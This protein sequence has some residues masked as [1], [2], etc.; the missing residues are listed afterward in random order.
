LRDLQRYDEAISGLAARTKAMEESQD[1]AR[2]V[3]RD[4]ET[5]VRRLEA[6][7]DQSAMVSPA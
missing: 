2:Q 3:W 6:E 4:L 1:K 7:R 5:R